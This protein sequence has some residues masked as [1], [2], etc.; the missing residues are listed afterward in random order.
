M[1]RTPSLSDWA[2]PLFGA[3]AGAGAIVAVVALPVLDLPAV[4]PEPASV[5]I[6]PPSAGQTLVCTGEILATARDSTAVD[7]ITVAAS[8]AVVTAGEGALGRTELESDAAGAAPLVLRSSAGSAPF[9]AAGSATVGDPDLSGF[10]ASACRVPLLDSW[11]VAGAGTTGAADLVVLSNPGEVA[12][13]VTLTVYGASG[14]D[15]PPGGADIVVR[16]GAQRIVPVAG[17][18]LGEQSPV[19]HVQAAGAPVAA[20]LQSSITRVLE[21]GG[22]DQAGALG[23]LAGRQ[24]IPGVTVTEGALSTGSGLSGTIVRVLSPQS[25]TEATISV[26][27]VGGATPVIDPV[28]VQLAAGIPAAIEMP[29]VPV[30][31]Y[32]VDV[33]AGEPVAAAVWQTT[34]FGAASDFA[35]YQPSPVIDTDA[36]IAVP[37]GPAPVLTIANP[38]TD[39]IAVDL[40]EPGTEPVTIAIAA[41]SSTQ[42]PLRAATTYELTGGPVLASVGYAGA[43][44]LAAFPVS[45]TSAGQEPIIVHP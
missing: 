32:I 35:W 42:V 38:G 34:G 24:T 21:P 37:T 1:T 31:S 16:P 5:A 8:Q 22:V 19:I 26:R 45:P 13:T 17:I 2:R 29:S 30:G 25:T 4:A 9:A 15:V 20:S 28:T 3:L 39:D 12:A 7:A 11:L 27:A 18:A 23:E 33:D 44:A 10:S 36:V 14:A 6:A 40:R 41:G 43:G